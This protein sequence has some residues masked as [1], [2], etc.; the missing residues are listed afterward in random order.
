MPFSW[1]KASIYTTLIRIWL[2]HWVQF[3]CPARHNI[4]KPWISWRMKFSA[5][6]PL[7]THTSQEA[8]SRLLL[9]RGA[10]QEHLPGNN[11][12]FSFTTKSTT[13]SPVCHL[14]GL[15]PIKLASI[16]P[17][18]Q[19]F[20]LSVRLCPLVFLP[21]CLVCVFGRGHSLPFVLQLQLQMLNHS[22]TVPGKA[23]GSLAC[24]N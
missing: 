11:V 2:E 10:L 22:Q 9:L 16:C 17:I 12:D 13:K 20:D 7:L 18:T 21:L 4:Y 19:Y 14:L 6:R 15:L 23:T 5:F 8:Y 3:P 1:G 24:Q